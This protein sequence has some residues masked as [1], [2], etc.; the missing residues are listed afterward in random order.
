M[1]S[2]SSSSTCSQWYIHGRKAVIRPKW[3]SGQL[4]EIR[5]EISRLLLR[6]VAQPYDRLAS[7]VANGQ[8]Q[9]HLQPGQAS[10]ADTGAVLIAHS[11]SGC[12]E[13]Q[14]CDYR[15]A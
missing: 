2:S 10:H 14:G 5:S 6:Q 8:Q 15:G 3:C 13:D 12:S 9:Q 7:Q 1:G 11:I 4:S